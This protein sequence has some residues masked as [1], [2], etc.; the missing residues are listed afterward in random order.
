MRNKDDAEGLSEMADPT[1]WDKLAGTK[2]INDSD[3]KPLLLPDHAPREWLKHFM[4]HNYIVDEVSS[5]VRYRDEWYVWHGTHF[6]Q[7]PASFLEKQ[8]YSF[9]AG[10]RLESDM[11]GGEP[12]HPTPA[13]V[14]AVLKAMA[15]THTEAKELVAPFRRAGIDSK[16]LPAQ[17]I[18][19]KNGRFDPLTGKLRRHHPRIFSTSCLPYAYDPDAPK[20]SRWLQFL[21]E[22]WPGDEYKQDRINLRKLFGLLLTSEMKFHKIFLFVGKPRSGKGTIINVLHGLLGESNIASLS[23]PTLSQRFGPSALLDKSV[24]IVPDARLPDSHQ[25]VRLSEKLLSIAGGDTQPIE[26][27]FK[28]HM[29]VKLS[30]RILIFTNELPKFTDSSGTL[31]TRFVISTMPNSFLK[32]PDLDLYEKSLQPEL[33]GILNWA[34]DG[35]AMLRS[36]EHFKT[37]PR[38]ASALQT[39]A[40]TASAIATFFNEHLE[41]HSDATIE[42]APLFRKYKTWCEDHNLTPGSSLMFTRDLI[43]QAPQLQVH[44]NGADRYYTGIG[45]RGGARNLV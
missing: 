33:P 35:L 37:P 11:S 13:D 15:S 25:L 45:L 43:S 19:L 22:V 2:T 38:S 34:L 40:E 21:H 20:P 44:G 4:L 5:V 39:L 6:K 26:K 3:G 32:K 28:D 1:A 7:V 30:T 18:M 14:S 23:L 8:L 9:L 41:V 42:H 27:K 12:F 17:T 29:S 36:V 31:P 10:C 16:L 24:C